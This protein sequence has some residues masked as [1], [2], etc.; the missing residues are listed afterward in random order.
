MTE[1]RVR[2]RDVKPYEIV[3]DLDELRGP[4]TGTVTL[5]VDVYWSGPF[6]TFDVGDEDD[7][8]LVYQAALS[9][10]RREHIRSFVN[11]DLL[12]QDW[13]RLALDPRVVDLW[14][15]GFPEIAARGRE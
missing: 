15:R 6:D 7:R 10:G 13:P 5:P 2:F 12:I 8:A 3:D 4:T 1:Q 9:N 11:R 14:T